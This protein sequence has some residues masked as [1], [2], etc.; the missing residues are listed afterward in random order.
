MNIHNPFNEAIETGT[1]TYTNRVVLIDADDLRAAEK[2]YDAAYHAHKSFE[3]G[4]NIRWW[5]ACWRLAE[6]KGQ[7]F[8]VKEN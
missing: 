7:L 1:V 5:A 8:T 2:E 6:V 4:S 3:N